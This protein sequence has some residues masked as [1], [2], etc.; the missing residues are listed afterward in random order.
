ML[1]GGRGRK[2]AAKSYLRTISVRAAFYFFSFSFI[3]VF[4]SFSLLLLM[5]NF[6]LKY[7]LRP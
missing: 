2:R 7:N 4:T 1:D 5:T 6:A 3:C